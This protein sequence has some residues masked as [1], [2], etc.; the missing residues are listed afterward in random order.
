MR[1]REKVTKYLRTLKYI[2]LPED[3]ET[4]IDRLTLNSRRLAFD[5]LTTLA[6][7]NPN[8]DHPMVRKWIDKY[9]IDY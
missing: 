6:L 4:L 8:A 1:L 7:G 3:K 9:T 5:I 2:G